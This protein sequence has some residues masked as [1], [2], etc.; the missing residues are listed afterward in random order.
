MILV[1][2]I[3]DKD[4]V[5]VSF[6][7]RENQDDIYIDS[8]KRKPKVVV[9]RGKKEVII[10]CTGNLSILDLYAPI[11][12]NLEEINKD[13][14][15]QSIMSF[16]KDYRD[17]VL[18]ERNECLSGSLIIAYKDKAYSVSS[19]LIVCEIVDYDA[20]GS[21]FVSALGILKAI[22]QLDVSIPIRAYLA[23]KATGEKYI[24][25]YVNV[26][27]LFNIVYRANLILLRFSVSRDM[28]AIKKEYQNVRFQFFELYSGLECKSIDST[29]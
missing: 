17:T 28:I 18:V 6:D 29:W 8:Y 11:V 5:I 25:T 12:S 15:L 2:A 7:D 24:D 16:C 13:T 19:N 4:R 10:G 9:Y 27:N 22:E 23:V 20:I 1:V 14:I 26:A 21:R 3:K